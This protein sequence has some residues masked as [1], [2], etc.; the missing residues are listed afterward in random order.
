MESGNCSHFSKELREALIYLRIYETGTEPSVCSTPLLISCS[1]LYAVV[2][3][4]AFSCHVVS[5]VPAWQHTFSMTG[6]IRGME[7]RK[8]S[9]GV[10]FFVI[11]SAGSC[12]GSLYNFPKS[13][14][15]VQTSVCQ[16]CGTRN[17]GHKV[18]GD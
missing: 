12:E 14:L 7:E 4:L 1:F 13:S 18:A 11:G 8:A 10:S 15:M 3:C 5:P 9:N 6:S 16:D 17:T 2:I